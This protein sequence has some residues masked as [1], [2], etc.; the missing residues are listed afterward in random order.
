VALA[1]VLCGA[2]LGYSFPIMFALVVER[3]PADE[4]GS[5]M[6]AFT[7]TGDT[8][9]L[10]GSPLLGWVIFHFDYSVMFYAAAALMAVTTVVYALW[11]TRRRSRSE[12]VPS[13]AGS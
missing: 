1:G 2:G 13:P 3:A 11:E 7:T 5:A 6:A 12:P 4:R 10:I 9:A 8:G